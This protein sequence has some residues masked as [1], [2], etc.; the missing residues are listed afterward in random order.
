R[1]VGTSRPRGD[2]CA[3]SVARG[4]RAPGT[5]YIEGVAPFALSALL[6]PAHHRGRDGG[7]AHVL[8]RI[9]DQLPDRGVGAA[10]VG[11]HRFAHAGGGIAGQRVEIRDRDHGSAGDPG[12]DVVVTFADVARRRRGRRVGV[13]RGGAAH[14]RIFVDD[15]VPVDRDARRPR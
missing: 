12:A 13:G 4:Y 14:G 9:L 8:V 3:R 1:L 7:V 6:Q 2:G 5:F 10:R 11:R 15:Q